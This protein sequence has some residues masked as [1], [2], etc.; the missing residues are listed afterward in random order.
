MLRVLTA[1]TGPADLGKYR[2]IP[3]WTELRQHLPDLGAPPA[4]MDIVGKTIA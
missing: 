1:T 4:E 3:L 2:L